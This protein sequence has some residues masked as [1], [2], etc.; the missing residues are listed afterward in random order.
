M[1]RTGGPVMNMAHTKMLDIKQDLP[2]AD[3]KSN[4]ACH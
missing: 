3:V 2:I 1:L 4:R